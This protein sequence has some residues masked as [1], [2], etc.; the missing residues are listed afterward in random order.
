MQ[1]PAQDGAAFGSTKV[2]NRVVP[3]FPETRHVRN[4]WHYRL[5]HVPGKLVTFSPIPR[6]YDEALRSIEF[7]FGVNVLFVE[8]GESDA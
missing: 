4:F 8:G 1:T 2:C 6:S 7:R 5:K 3:N